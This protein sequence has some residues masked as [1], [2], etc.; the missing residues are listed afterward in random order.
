MIDKDFK[1]QDQ[2]V[3]EA[4]R[5]KQNTAAQWLLGVLGL[6]VGAISVGVATGLNAVPLVEEQST[7]SLPLPEAQL[8]AQEQATDTNDEFAPTWNQFTVKEGDTL[9]MLL[10]RARVS[11]QQLHSLLAQDKKYKSMLTHLVPE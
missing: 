6:A 5:R 4:P 2:T 1:H 10:D 3:S 11:P 8:V 9:A 7:V